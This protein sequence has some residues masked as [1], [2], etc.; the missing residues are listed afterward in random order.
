MKFV[1]ISAATG[2]SPSTVS[3]VVHGSESISPKTA[4][5]MEELGHPALMADDRTILFNKTPS[6]LHRAVAV[7]T[8]GDLWPID[9]AVENAVHLLVM[10]LRTKNP[11][12]PVQIASRPRI[13]H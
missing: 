3:R 12:Q 1:D 10:R 5:L 11:R 7:L 2:V 6:F 13:I 8:F 9:I 4:S